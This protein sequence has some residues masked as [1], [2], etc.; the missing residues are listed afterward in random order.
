MWLGSI[1]LNTIVTSFVL[2]VVLVAGFVL[3]WPELPVLPL[4]LLAVAVVAI[5]PVLFFP[6]SRTLW[7]AI[8]L[9]IRP[10]TPEEFGTDSNRLAN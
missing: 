6:I 8:D 7:L 9:A 3:T 2:F 10:A 4:T 1:G 5:W